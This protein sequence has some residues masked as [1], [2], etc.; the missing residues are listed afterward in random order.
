MT[1]DQI[2][3]NFIKFFREVKGYTAWTDDEIIFSMTDDDIKDYVNYIIK[4]LKEM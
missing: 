4:E 2:I 3:E 1:K